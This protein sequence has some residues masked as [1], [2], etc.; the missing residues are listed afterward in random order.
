MKLIL[1]APLRLVLVSFSLLMVMLLSALIAPGAL[2]SVA[3]QTTTGA[4][5]G[6]VVNTAGAAVPGAAVTAGQTTRTTDAA[7][8]FTISGLQPTARLAVNVRANGYIP[9]TRIFMVAA[10]ATVLNNV[11]LTNQAAPI[12]VNI[13][14]G[15]VLPI[16]GTS[17]TLTI[18]AGSLVD[19]NGNEV[20]GV[21][22]ARMSRIDVTQPAQLRS[23]PGDFT[24]VM[25][26][27]TQGQ[28]ETAGMFEFLIIDSA[29]NR[30]ELA[31]GRTALLSFAPGDLPFVGT[32]MGLYTFDSSNGRWIERGEIKQTAAATTGG[33]RTLSSMPLQRTGPVQGTI[34][35]LR[36]VW[37]IDKP[38]NWV[39]IRVKVVSKT[40]VLLP[41]RGVTATGV[42]FRGFS[43]NYTDTTGVTCL[44][45]PGGAT[46]D[47]N[48]VGA[49]PVRVTVPTTTAP[50]CTDP[51]VPVYTVQGN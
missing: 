25:L 50:N 16:A 9:T 14:N 24:A 28:L 26:N 7:G 29:G 39:W 4:I 5:T 8:N 12:S 51:G 22:S 40:G 19:P 35:T 30:A 48:S 6:R 32:S 17:G 13:D 45:V 23:A 3:T 20:R 46:I 2:A 34:N 27:G 36:V 42:N 15:A 33:G 18:P 49:P 11:T 1:S 41:Y 38:F 10:G 37:N 43:E 44:R 47:I 31:P 21:V